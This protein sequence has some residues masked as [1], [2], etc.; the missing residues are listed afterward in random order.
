MAS[1]MAVPRSSRSAGSG[2]SGS[3]VGR[4][5]PVVAHPMAKL[6]NTADLSI[7]GTSSLGMRQRSNLSADVVRKDVSVNLTRVSTSSSARA[8]R[9]NDGADFGRKSCPDRIIQWPPGQYKL[10]FYY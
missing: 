1:S 8:A 6:G 9:E 7:R 2:V 10:S 3:G 4:N 5:I